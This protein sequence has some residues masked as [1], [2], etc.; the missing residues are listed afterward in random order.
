[1]HKEDDG[2]SDGGVQAESAAPRAPSQS[3]GCR[4]RPFPGSQSC[5]DR[6]AT[7]VGVA[8]LKHQLNHLPKCGQHLEVEERPFAIAGSAARSHQAP[9][10]RAPLFPVNVRAGKG[11]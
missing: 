7:N 11:A 2:K 9:N 8:G 5:S 4:A 6:S 3:P 10:P 1:M